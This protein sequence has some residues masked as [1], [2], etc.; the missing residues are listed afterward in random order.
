[1]KDDNYYM[2]LCIQLA[3]AAKIKGNPAVGCIIVKNGHIIAKAEETSQS[4]G[5]ITCHAEIEVIRE[6][7]K[8]IGSDLSGCTLYTTHEPCVMCAYPIRYH[9]ISKIVINSP[10][11][12]FGGT[13]SEFP[14]LTTTKVPSHWSAPPEIGWLNNSAV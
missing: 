8:K 5:D 7:V 2:D 12:F 13:G 9:A 11:T 14:L 4:K 3:N 6:T 1:M 10:V